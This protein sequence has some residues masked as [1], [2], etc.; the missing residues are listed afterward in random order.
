MTTLIQSTDTTRQKWLEEI[1]RA[2]NRFKRAGWEFIFLLRDGIDALP[3]NDQERAELYED[4]ASA[5]GLAVH[6]LQNYVSAARKPYARL[7]QTKG[8]EMGHLDAV[9]GVAPEIAEGILIDAAENAWTVARTRA[10]AYPRRTTP[11]V[12]KQLA[13]AADDYLSADKTPWESDADPA[14]GPAW[15]D[16]FLTIPREPVAAAQVIRRE[17]DEGE[18][19]ALIDALLR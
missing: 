10:E 4:A 3:R 11:D 8:L 18:I 15:N 13:D 5:T 7:A 2:Y 1:E 19:A 14:A 16:D 9:Q 6:T 12:G 17:Y